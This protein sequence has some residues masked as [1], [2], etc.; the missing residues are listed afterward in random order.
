MDKNPQKR[1]KVQGSF[2][3]YHSIVD[4]LIIVSII[5][6]ECRKN[7]ANLLCFFIDDV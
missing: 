7:K 1:D 3:G 6:E 4:Q 5:V 2:I